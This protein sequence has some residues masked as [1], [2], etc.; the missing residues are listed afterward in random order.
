[1]FKMF[2]IVLKEFIIIKA[3]M[4]TLTNIL[5]IFPGILY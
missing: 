3:K 2:K 4:N 5:I 1:M